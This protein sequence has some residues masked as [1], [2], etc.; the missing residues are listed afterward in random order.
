MKKQQQQQTWT[1]SSQADCGFCPSDGAVSLHG[2]GGAAPC[3]VIVCEAKEARR[4]TPVF[5]GHGVVEDRVYCGAQVEE[6]HGH[7]AA[8]LRQH[9]Q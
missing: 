7:H 5:P 6:N 4:C 8:V 1:I 9:G 2:A 3:R